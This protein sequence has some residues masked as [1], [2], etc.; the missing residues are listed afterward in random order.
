MEY[1]EF[2][3]SIQSFE[4]KTKEILTVETEDYIEMI[5]VS[6][7]RRM[8]LSHNLKTGKNKLSI[9]VRATISDKKINITDQ[10]YYSNQLQNMI[11]LCKYL[12]TLQKYS[13]TI[14]S[15]PDEGIWYA[16]IELK[17]INIDYNLFKL[18]KIEK[19]EI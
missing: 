13:F 7:Y 15:L 8:F 18:L 3:G 5:F 6:N 12:L 11:Y 4:G 9:E 2:I 19:V 17:N 10:S 14:D 16:T 1:N